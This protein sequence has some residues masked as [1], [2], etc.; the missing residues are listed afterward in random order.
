VGNLGGTPAGPVAYADSGA[1]LSFAFAAL[2]TATDDVEFSNDNGS[3]WTYT[4]VPDASGFDP[5]VTNTRLR[6]KGR[7]AGYGG[8]G[9]YPAFTFSFKVRVR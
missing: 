7:M 9:A 1:G 6:P 5:V 4:P 2:A 8:S 3:T